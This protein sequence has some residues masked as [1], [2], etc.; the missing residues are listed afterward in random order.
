MAIVAAEDVVTVMALEAILAVVAVVA[1]VV[2]AAVVAVEAVVTITAI[3][4][5]RFI[6][7]RFVHDR[8][9]CRGIHTKQSR[10]LSLSW[11]S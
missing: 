3:E 5:V 1:V 7:R 6:L 8:S 4:A 11:P 10:P 9:S 2:V